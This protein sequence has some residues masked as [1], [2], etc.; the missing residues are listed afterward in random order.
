MR[1]IRT[2]YAFSEQKFI[3]M[4]HLVNAVSTFGYKPETQYFPTRVDIP[5]LK[6]IALSSGSDTVWTGSVEGDVY[7]SVQ[8]DGWSGF[9]RISSIGHNIRELERSP[10]DRLFAGCNLES[11]PFGAIF[12]SSDGG[13]TWDLVYTGSTTDRYTINTITFWDGQYG[14]AGGDGG[15][16]LRTSDGGSS[17]TSSA[18]PSVFD[19]RSILGTAAT[20]QYHFWAVTSGESL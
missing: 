16:F 13:V 7:M 19:Y 3:A 8:D 4:K 11:T 15:T 6:G 12:S 5:D 17:W 18:E 1:L 14:L 20:G 9:E 2:R 10:S